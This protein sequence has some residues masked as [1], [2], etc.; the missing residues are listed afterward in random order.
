M[1]SIIV[2]IICLLLVIFIISSCKKNSNPVE[3]GNIDNSNYF[4]STAGSSYKY[5][6][7]RTNDAGVQTTGTRDTK[8]ENT[9]E[10]GGIYTLQVDSVSTVDSANVY[11]SYFRKTDTGIYYYLDTTG[12]SENLPAEYVP[13]IPY[14]K[15][16][17]E[18]L[19]FSTPLQDG[20]NWPVFKVNL[21]EGI[22]VTVVDVEAKYAGKENIALN[23]NS[24]TVTKEAVKIEYSFSLINPIT[25]SRQTVTADGWF[26][27]D[28]GAVK[29]EGNGLLLNVF[30]RSE[31]NFSDSTSTGSENLLSYD[32]K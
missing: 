21:E 27:A 31:I 8:Y 2:S 9:A 18:M 24:G 5:N 20:K 28:I 11:N 13:Y 14:L 25:Q 19:L 15:I 3:A 29:W 4:P 16:D 12:F 32:I 17:Q 23:L 1:K 10:R 30:T 6:F 7:E 26:V 22:T